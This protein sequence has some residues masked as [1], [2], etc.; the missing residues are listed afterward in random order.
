MG[1]DEKRAGPEREESSEDVGV[2]LEVT[3]GEMRD[4]RGE[5]QATGPP[6]APR[7]PPPT[8]AGPEQ[9]AVDPTL[10][11]APRGT[12]EG[13][14]APREA[15]SPRPPSADSCDEERQ[16]RGRRGRRSSAA[17]RSHDADGHQKDQDH[18]PPS[19]SETPEAEGGAAGLGLAPWQTDFNFEDVLKPVA[20]RGRQLV[21][22]S[23]R[24]LSGSSEESSA[25]LAW[26]PHTSPDSIRAGRRRTRGRSL[27]A[28]P[29]PLSE[30]AP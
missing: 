30:E 15:P 14:A 2:Q 1:T 20:S 10:G 23:L 24:N 13:P 25:G 3:A 5:D 29:P 16:R 6:G 4:E 19:A 26:L 11:Q 28:A 7:E 12:S 8:E 17:G 18:V 22:R 27:T 21:R 9:G